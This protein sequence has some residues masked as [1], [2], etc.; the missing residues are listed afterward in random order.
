MSM[1]EWWTDGLDTPA[2]DVNIS[3]LVEIV[4]GDTLNQNM[5]AFDMHAT[6]VIKFTPGNTVSTSTNESFIKACDF[7]AISV[8]KFTSLL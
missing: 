2:T 8:I 4:S 7:L 5:K 1:E 3:P 6:N